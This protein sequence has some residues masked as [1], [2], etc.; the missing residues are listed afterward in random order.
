[1]RKPPKPKSVNFE[2]IPPMDGDHEPEPHKIL[3]E[4][5]NKF[6]KDL[7]QAKIALAWRKKLK[8]DKDGHLTLGKCVKA[9]D[10]SRALAPFADFVILLNREV[11][12]DMD[13][14]DKKKKALIDHELCHAAPVFNKFGHQAYDEEGRAIWRM[15]RHDIEEF[16]EIVERH[17]FYKHD[18]EMFA[19]A[20]LA[21]KQTP[22]LPGL[23]QPKRNGKHVDVN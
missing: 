18:L 12:R 17:G 9:S 19:K 5:R 21:K 15:R 4:I 6:H 7:D 2:L 23:E 16:T 1:M 13:F 10:L 3:R 11:W 14:T 22:I 20:V 8:A